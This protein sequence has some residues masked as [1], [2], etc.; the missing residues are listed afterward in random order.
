MDVSEFLLKRD[1]P[2]EGKRCESC[3]S[4]FPEFGLP[5]LFEHWHN[6]REDWITGA[7][8]VVEHLPHG[9][10]WVRRLASVLPWGVDIEEASVP[11]PDTMQA[12]PDHMHPKDAQAWEVIEMLEP[13]HYLEMSQD[14]KISAMT[15]EEWENR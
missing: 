9:A 5:P 14:F 7:T 12:H 13:V 4:N 1:L 10:W 3:G 11:L 8:E 6:C 2:P 15:P